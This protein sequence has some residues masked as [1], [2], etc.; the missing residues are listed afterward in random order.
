MHKDEFYNSQ[1]F[2]PSSVMCVCLLKKGLPDR[3]KSPAEG[4]N[5]WVALFDTK[6]E[7]RISSKDPEPFGIRHWWAGGKDEEVQE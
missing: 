2:K 7:A 1:F 5:L 4:L 6:G 3:V